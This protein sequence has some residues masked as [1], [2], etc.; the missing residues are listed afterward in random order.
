MALQKLAP[1]SNV[2]V[3]Y[4]DTIPNALQRAQSLSNSV[5]NEF[6]ILRGWF[7]IS[8]AAFG[9]NDRVSVFLD[10]PDGSGAFN[11]GYQS[12]GQSQIHL[13]VQ[14]GNMSAPNADEIVRMLFVA[15]VVEVFM[16]Y[17]AQN[18]N[19]AWD[20][21]DSAGEG[22]SQL[23][24]IERVHAGHYL[25]YQSFVDSWL[26]WPPMPCPFKKPPPLPTTPRKDWITKSEPTDKD[27]Y[28]FG[29]ALLFL[30][31][32]KSQLNK[33][34]PEIIQKAG[35][36][37]EATYTN[38]TGQT[39]GFAALSN[40]LNQFMP[41]GNTPL[42][43]TSDD[44]FPF[45]DAAHR[46]LTID[47][48][49]K[50]LGSPLIV[51][52]GQA[53]VK[54]FFTCPAKNY[55]FN[56]EST[57]QQVTCTASTFGFAQPLFKWKVNGVDVTGNGSISATVQLFVADKTNPQ[58][59]TLVTQTIQIFVTTKDERLTSELVVTCPNTVGDISLLV[60]VSAVEKV[61]SKDVSTATQ[62][63][64][65]NNQ[66]VV[67]EDKYGKD[68]AACFSEFRERIRH[69]VIAPPFDRLNWTIAVILTL[70]DPIPDELKNAVRILEQ[71]A[72][73][74]EL[75]RKESPAKAREVTKLLQTRLGLNEKT[76]RN[77]APSEKG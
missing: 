4:E 29:C 6:L 10:Q 75:L 65:I 23:C 70:P 72:L 30:Y 42:L 55:H 67:W 68:F 2:L 37:L 64:G 15:E 28:S 18:G 51:S 54:P 61:A 1:T 49:K 36:T 25:Y 40:L 48:T 44:P 21:S 9:P 41:I 45:L 3:Q 24:S 7:G 59:S 60:E 32:L 20:P 14:S 33:S 8:G 74:L 13:D 38:L 34:I 17:N 39:G 5:E 16:N 52:S 35:K 43:K 50:N 66:T 53:T 69:T 63:I 57:P 76:L 26:Q 11:Q 47:F 71:A 77:L 22:L 62:W 58:N 56:I 12:G 46:S 19:V 27:C 31:Y 73:E